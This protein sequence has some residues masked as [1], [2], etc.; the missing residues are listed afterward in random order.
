MFSLCSPLSGSKI[1]N[2]GLILLVFR[3]LRIGRKPPRCWGDFI[4]EMHRNISRAG[5]DIHQHHRHYH[6]HHHPRSLSSVLS[7]NVIIIITIILIKIFRV[8]S[9]SRQIVQLLPVAS[10]PCLENSGNDF[11]GSEEK[12]FYFFLKL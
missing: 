11:Q 2:S 6:Q 3:P 7:S 10:S 12:T 4:F 1:T 9:T 8:A 5:N